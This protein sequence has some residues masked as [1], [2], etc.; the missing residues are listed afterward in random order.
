MTARKCFDI[1]FPPDRGMMLRR[2]R[3]VQIFFK[4][5]KKVVCALCR[6]PI[7]SGRQ[8]ICGRTSRGLTGGER[9][10]RISPPSFC[11]AC[12]NFCRE[13]DSTFP[14]P[15]R[16]RSRILCTHELIV[17]HLLGMINLIYFFVCLPGIYL[18]FVKK[19]PSSCDCT[20]IR[21]HVPTSEGFEVTN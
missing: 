1:F 13:K 4:T 11:G 6:H 3:C 12:L 8:I 7:Y 16:P 21:T 10:H 2:S 5:V 19:N 20:K 14:F 18:F 17:L 9:S 15:R